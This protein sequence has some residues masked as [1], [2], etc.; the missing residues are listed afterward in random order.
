MPTVLE[1][2]PK[3]T[4]PERVASPRAVVKRTEKTP[5]NEGRPLT[6]IE[7]VV[8]GLRKVFEGHEEFLGWTPD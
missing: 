8:K 5:E 2:P 7:R 6:R 1:Q 4:S 3:V